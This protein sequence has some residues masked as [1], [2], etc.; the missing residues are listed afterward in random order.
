MLLHL[1]VDALIVAGAVSV[2]IVL[3]IIGL[4]C[5]ITSGGKDPMY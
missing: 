2:L 1:L 5:W 4:H 3:S